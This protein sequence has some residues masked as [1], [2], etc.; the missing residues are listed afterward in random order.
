MLIYIP[1]SFSSTRHEINTFHTKHPINF[2]N[3]HRASLLGTYPVLFSLFQFTTFMIK[4]GKTALHEIDPN[5]A[6]KEVRI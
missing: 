2:T 3:F 5:L 4:D 6:L 1:C